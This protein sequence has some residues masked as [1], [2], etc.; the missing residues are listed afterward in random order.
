MDAHHRPHK[1][2][3]VACERHTKGFSRRDNLNAHVKTHQ[4]SP[5]RDQRSSSDPLARLMGRP[6][7]IR[8]QLQRMS[9][10]ERKEIITVV[11]LCLEMGFDDDDRDD[12]DDY[13]DEEGGIDGDY[14]EE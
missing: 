8:K 2:P 3:N 14:G 1:C 11:L 7:G 4:K 9:G 10:Y 6:S 13:D 5:T 12:G